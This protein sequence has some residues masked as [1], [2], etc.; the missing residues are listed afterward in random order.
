MV[1]LPRRLALKRLFKISRKILAAGGLMKITYF[2]TYGFR[3]PSLDKGHRWLLS[4]IL[5]GS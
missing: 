2:Q 4:F 3:P 1:Y 5:T